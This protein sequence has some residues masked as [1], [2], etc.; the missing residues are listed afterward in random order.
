MCS[1][2]A[3]VLLLC[4]FPNRLR[5]CFLARKAAAERTSFPLKPVPPCSEDLVQELTQRSALLLEKQW[6]PAALSAVGSAVKSAAGS[7]V[8]SAAGAILTRSQSQVRAI[9][10]W[11]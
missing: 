2:P 10:K 7:A 1:D 11:D 6:I 9:P 4:L 8:G 3:P 5:S